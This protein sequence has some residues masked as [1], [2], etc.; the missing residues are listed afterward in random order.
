MASSDIPI[1]IDL[2]RSSALCYNNVMILTFAR[3]GS[4][5]L[6]NAEIARWV[7]LIILYITLHVHAQDWRLYESD[8]L[9]SVN[10]RWPKF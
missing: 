6:T 5:P 3:G 8:L 10:L 7:R 4:S 9:A 1:F 2:F